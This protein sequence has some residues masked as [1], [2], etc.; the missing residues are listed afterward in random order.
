[1]F[2]IYFFQQHTTNDH[3]KTIQG[4][5]SRA[6]RVAPLAMEKLWWV[7]VVVV[8]VLHLKSDRVMPFSWFVTYSYL[9]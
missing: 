1:M 8:V 2:I 5:R 6:E 9:L 3:I 4:L 7:V